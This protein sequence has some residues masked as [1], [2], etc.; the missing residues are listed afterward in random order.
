MVLVINYL[1]SGVVECRVSSFHYLISG[2]FVV[3]EKTPVFMRVDILFR[4]HRKH[5]Q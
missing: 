2:L 4:S 5:S 1:N 3:S